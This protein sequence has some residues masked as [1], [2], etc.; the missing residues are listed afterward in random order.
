[1]EKGFSFAET[2]VMGADLQALIKLLYQH[3]D[4]IASS[5]NDLTPSKLPPLKA[6]TLDAQ[7]IRARPFRYSLQQQEQINQQVKEL[8]A[9]NIITETDSPWSNA[10]ILV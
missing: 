1:M 2:S 9:A 3:Q 5:L 10:I 6:E 4:L 7:P 8:L